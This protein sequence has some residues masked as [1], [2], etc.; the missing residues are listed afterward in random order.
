MTVAR[1]RKLSKSFDV[2]VQRRSS[3]PCN[4]LAACQALFGAARLLGT[5]FSVVCRSRHSPKLCP[6]GDITRVALHVLAL[7]SGSIDMAN[8]QAVT[9]VV[10]QRLFTAILYRD[11]CSPNF[12][13]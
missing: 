10:A 9:H 4:P 12:A 5:N 2:G 3:E 1:L 13:S 7:S 6:P 8:R 11:H